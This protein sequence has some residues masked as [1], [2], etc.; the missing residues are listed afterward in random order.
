ALKPNQPEAHTFTDHML[1]FYYADMPVVF[2]AP[3][4][5]SKAKSV[6]QGTKPG[7]KSG[8][9]KLSTSSKPP[10]M[11][12]REATNGGSAKAPTQPKTGKGANSIAR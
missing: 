3:K 4:T 8:Y 6:S 10:F 12:S 7:A 1:V 2:K 11:S 9:K 5:S